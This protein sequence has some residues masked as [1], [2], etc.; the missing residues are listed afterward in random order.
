MQG[1]NWTSCSFGGMI[2]LPKH[3]FD[4][5]QS[6]PHA[7]LGGKTR[8]SLELLYVGSKYALDVTAEHILSKCYVI[9]SLSVHERRLESSDASLVVVQVSPSQAA[10]TMT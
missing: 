4:C 3:I 10:I 7:C 8:A 5:C 2:V 6:T 9:D 1:A